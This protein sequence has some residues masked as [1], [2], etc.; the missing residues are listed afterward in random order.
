ML[1][2]IYIIF[3]KKEKLFQKA[4]H[5]DQH[6]KFSRRKKKNKKAMNDEKPKKLFLEQ[7][8]K[9]ILNLRLI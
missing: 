9:P 8:K 2:S 1:S 4:K 7:E 3:R 6:D 5:R